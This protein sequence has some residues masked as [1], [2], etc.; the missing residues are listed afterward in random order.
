MQY[1][2]EWHSPFQT[3]FFANR[4]KLSSG[5]ALF[6]QASTKSV[7]EA[8]TLYQDAIEKFTFCM[9][10][11]PSYLAAAIN[12]GVAYMD[13]ARLNQAKPEDSLYLLAKK[14]V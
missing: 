11:N 4:Y 3:V 7:E 5:F 14:T 9:L 1:L 2:L 8:S 13:L 12:S 6:H 10:I